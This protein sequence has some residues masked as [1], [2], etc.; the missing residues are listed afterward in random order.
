LPE[1][2]TPTVLT[3]LSLRLET[4]FQALSQSSIRKFSLRAQFST[5]A[6]SCVLRLA[7]IEASSYVRVASAMTASFHGGMPR[8]THRRVKQRFVA[9]KRIL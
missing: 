8:G 6:A 2:W 5:G 1:E 9:E 3:A 7:G 4:C